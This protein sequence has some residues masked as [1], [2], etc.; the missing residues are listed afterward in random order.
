MS[1]FNRKLT[2]GINNS[3][4]ICTK[5]QRACLEEGE[6]SPIAAL[7][8]GLSENPE[9]NEELANIPKRPISNR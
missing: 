2:K 1:E 9:R 5:A 8:P 3:I 4:R 7:A 6:G